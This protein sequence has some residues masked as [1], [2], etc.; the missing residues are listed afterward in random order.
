LRAAQ[1]PRHYCRPTPRG[2]NARPWRHPVHGLTRK[3]TKPNTLSVG[4]RADCIRRHLTRTVSAHGLFSGH[5]D[6]L[7][8]LHKL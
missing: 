7:A 4:W 8:N 3:Q 1:A 6:A 5:S 2:A